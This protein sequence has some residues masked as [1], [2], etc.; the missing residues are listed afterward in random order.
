MSNPIFLKVPLALNENGQIVKPQDAHKGQNYICPGCGDKLTLRRGAV[1]KVHFAHRAS[2]VCNNETIIHNLAKRQIAQIINDYASGIGESPVIERKCE[3]CYQVKEQKLPSRQIS[4]Q[5]ERKLLSGYIADVA[6]LGENNEFVAA[7]EVKV[8]H[9][10]SEGKH[11]QMG[12]PYIEVE[13]EAILNNPYLWKPIRDKFKPIKC[14]NCMNL[15]DSYKERARLIAKKSGVAFPTEYYRTAYIEC[16]KCKKEILIFAWP[17]QRENMEPVRQPRP[18]SIQYRYS[19]MA[20]QKYWMNTCPYCNMSQ[21]D[22]FIFSEPDSPL[23]GFDCGADSD[24]AFNL[25][26]LTIALRCEN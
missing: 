17:R 14:N 5:L 22:F 11:W 23:F 4:A 12:L 20:G 19:K 6:V 1:K 25:D 7:I 15:L 2:E 16:W 26:M 9:A 13:G 3:A 24:E 21:G 8:T 10:V 18:R